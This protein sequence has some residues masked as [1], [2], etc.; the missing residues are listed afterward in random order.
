MVS[1]EEKVYQNRVQINTNECING[2]MYL[3]RFFINLARRTETLNFQQAPDV[4]EMKK[5][6]TKTIV[7]HEDLESL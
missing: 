1:T 2:E 6:K 5:Q 3:K 4:T 7:F